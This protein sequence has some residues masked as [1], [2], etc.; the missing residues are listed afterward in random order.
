MESADFLVTTVRITLLCSSGSHELGRLMRVE[1]DAYP[2]VG[3]VRHQGQLT[4]VWSDG[5]GH[6]VRQRRGLYVR[7]DSEG[8]PPTYIEGRCPR[9]R[10]NARPRLSWDRV[11]SLLNQAE[12]AGD[13][14]TDLEMAW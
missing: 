6:V 2:E 9:C 7:A 5:H 11:V 8:S 14:D 10:S 1:P 4:Q 3:R 13:R 12:G